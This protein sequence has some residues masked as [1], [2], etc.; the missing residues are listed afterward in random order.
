MAAH[1]NV[2][3]QCTALWA[4]RQ[5]IGFLGVVARAAQQRHRSVYSIAIIDLSD[6][7]KP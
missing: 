3:S 7:V 6:F 5:Q 2:I 1:G 4:M